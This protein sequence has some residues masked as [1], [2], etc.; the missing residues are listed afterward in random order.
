M[1]GKFLEGNAPSH[2][3]ENL[4]SLSCFI[5]DFFALPIA[6]SICSKPCKCILDYRLSPLRC[7]FGDSDPLVV[8]CEGLLRPRLRT[9]LIWVESK[10]HSPCLIFRDLKKGARLKVPQQQTLLQYP[11]N[12]QIL[13]SSRKKPSRQTLKIIVYITHISRKQKNP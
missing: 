13:P 9:L 2:S 3:F 8:Q 11:K 1:E 4:C 5:P 10:E 7:F 6:L 12:L